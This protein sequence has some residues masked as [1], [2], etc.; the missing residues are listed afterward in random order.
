MKENQ[1]HFIFKK[2]KK[3]MKIVWFVFFKQS[4]KYK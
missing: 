4:V 1:V 2:G 3:I